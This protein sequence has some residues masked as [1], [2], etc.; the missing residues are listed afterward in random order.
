MS[1][2]VKTLKQKKARKDHTCDKCG[3]IIQA[4]SIYYSEDSGDRF[5]QSLH[6]KKYCSSCYEQY[7]NQLLS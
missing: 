1:K 5:L 4:K 3:G 6:A 7:G 2:Y